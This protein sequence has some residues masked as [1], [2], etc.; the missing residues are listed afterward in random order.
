MAERFL[1]LSR[2]D[3]LEALG[4]AATE[5]GRPAHLLEK[6]IWAVWAVDALFS[7][8]FGDHLVFKGGTSLSKGYDIIKRFSEDVDVTYDVRQLLP[9]VAAA[10]P[11]PAT[12][13]Q[14]RKWSDLI[15]ERLPTWI[16]NEIVPILEAHA[17]A[18]GVSVKITADN[19][20][21][22]IDYD[23]LTKNSGYV[24]P[25]VTLEFGARS[26]GEPTETREITCDAAP[27]LTDLEFPTARPKLMLPKRTFW[28]KA[29]AA[30]VYCLNGDVGDRH[31]RHWHDLVRLDK[32][33]YAQ[34]AL[35]DRALAKE[36]ADFKSRFFRDKDRAGNQ[37]DYGVA[38][39]GKL[40]L[41]PDADIRKLLAEDYKKMADEGILLDEAEPF[42]DLMEQCNDLQKRANKV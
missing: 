22:Y 20:K 18:T 27:L 13:S 12:N 21:V 29:T 6:D 39:T 26:T 40:R 30:H 9:E 42:A 38:V 2:A 17:A 41:V 3:Q 33:G 15:K 24:A 10:N 11:L 23:P 4:V 28:E 19:D 14:A 5:S 37:I 31:S 36:I 32:T 7:S 1:N 8:R 35:A 25:R 16:K 34:Q